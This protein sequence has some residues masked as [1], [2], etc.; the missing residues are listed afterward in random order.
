MSNGYRSLGIAALTAAL[1][2]A[3]GLGA[4]WIGLPYP[5]KRYQPYQSSQKVENGATETVSDIAASVVER[6][7]CNNPQS[8]GESDLCA[9]WRAA[10]AA[11]KSADWTMWGVLSGMVG[12]SFLLWQIMLTR[13]AVKDTGNATAAMLIQNDITRD[14]GQAQVRSYLSISNATFLN[15]TLDGGTDGG[16]FCKI[17]NSGQSLAHNVRLEADFTY[18]DT[19]QKT[20]RT[21][22][23]VP[24][25]LAFEF[26]AP[27]GAHIDMRPIL[28]PYALSKSEIQAVNLGN[29]I[30]VEVEIRIFSK[31]V[32]GVS[33]QNK[34]FFIHHFND[35]RQIF[36]KYEMRLLGDAQSL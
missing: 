10:K 29:T 11:E 16:L 24:E 19:N 4:Y 9:Q 1:L 8:E 35:K 27:S 17:R 26:I 18:F 5:Q 20:I 33:H 34:E 31:D 14:I 2:I 28:G 32:F 12:I 25:S 15:S 30:C 21:Q 23:F 13:E 6:T 7:P 36:G 22:K 3:F